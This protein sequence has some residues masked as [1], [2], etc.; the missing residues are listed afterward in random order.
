[1]NHVEGDDQVLRVLVFV[2]SSERKIKCC[3]N[4]VHVACLKDLAKY[5]MK[6]A[7]VN[8]IKKIF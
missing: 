4:F 5:Y 1:M 2:A 7:L 6:D 8:V 3:K